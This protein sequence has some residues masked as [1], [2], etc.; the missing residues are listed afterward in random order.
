VF[1]NPSVNAG[2]SIDVFPAI[3]PRG[4]YAKPFN[5]CSV[6][7]VKSLLRGIDLS[8]FNDDDGTLDEFW[9]EVEENYIPDATKRAVGSMR[10]NYDWSKEVWFFEGTN[11]QNLTLPRREIRY[12]NAVFLRILPSLLWYRFTNIRNADGTE[13]ARIG[14]IEP[15]PSAPEKLPPDLQGLAS[16]AQYD[17]SVKTVQYTG[18]EDA[19]LLVDT[20]SR[21]LTIPPRVLYATINTPMYN[22]T[23]FQGDL[24][25]EVHFAYGFPPIAYS[26]GQLLSFDTNGNVLETSPA[27]GDKPGGASIDWSSAMPRALSMAVARITAADI[28]RR[29]WRSNTQGSSSLS[30][31]GGSESFG[32]SAFGGDADREEERGFKALE[33]FAIRML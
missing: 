5:H 3:K 16:L 24:N 13:F 30:I 12:V 6:R 11:T 21:T 27:T 9:Q 25:V 31:D 22:W 19:D 28:L 4:S 23:F 1:Q 18:M 33:P 2:A 7:Q 32:S 29:V 15:P 10:T 26:D 20:R 17:G 14:G 8:A